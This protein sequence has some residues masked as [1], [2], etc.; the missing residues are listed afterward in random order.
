LD[1][2][3]YFRQYRRLMA[4]W[5]RCYGADLFELHYDSFV[6]QPARE[7]ARLFNFLGL[8]WDERYLAVESRSEAIKTA[9]VWQVREPIYTRS[10]GRAAHYAPQLRELRDYLADL[11]PK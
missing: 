3:H 2:G 11:L 1:I 10:S 5:Q 6:R 7:A 8:E 4:H 9:S